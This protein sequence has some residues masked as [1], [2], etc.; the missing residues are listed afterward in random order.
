VGKILSGSDAAKQ[1][2]TTKAGPV[3]GF[4]L[5]KIGADFELG[6]TPEDWLA[7]EAVR[8]SP[9]PAVGVSSEGPLAAT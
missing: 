9:C 7:A 3:W 2:G 4:D 1:I 8:G 6:F 5:E